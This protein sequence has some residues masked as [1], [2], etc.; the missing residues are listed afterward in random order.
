MSVSRSARRRGGDCLNYALDPSAADLDGGLTPQVTARGT[1]LVTKGA[2]S[3]AKQ[4]TGERL[5]RTCHFHPRPRRAAAE[6]MATAEGVRFQRISTAVYTPGVAA[7][8]T[9]G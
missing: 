1:S 9:R 5:R 8:V 4:A 6:F 3:S 7:K 2:R